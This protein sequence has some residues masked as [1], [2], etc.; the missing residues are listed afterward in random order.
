MSSDEI[1]CDVERR[2]NHVVHN[3]KMCDSQTLCR[4]FRRIAKLCILWL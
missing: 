2:G 1:I 3:F 4:I